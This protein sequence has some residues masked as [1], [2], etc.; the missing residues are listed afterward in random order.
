MS[1]FPVH[2]IYIVSGWYI[3][4][5]ILDILPQTT[6]PWSSD[7][8]GSFRYIEAQF[9]IDMHMYIPIRI[10]LSIIHMTF[11]CTDFSVNM[12]LPP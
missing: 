6:L 3:Y 9:N 10:S 4:I 12:I 2:V 1:D 7:V 8:T 5:H 11:L